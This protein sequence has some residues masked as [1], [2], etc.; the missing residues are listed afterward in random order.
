MYKLKKN[1]SLKGGF[2]NDNVNRLLIKLHNK[3]YFYNLT[4]LTMC[5]S[6]CIITFHSENPTIEKYKAQTC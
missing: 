6:I 3:H 1:V 2:L 5:H 4:L